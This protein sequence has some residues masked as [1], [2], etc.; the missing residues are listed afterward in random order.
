MPG[1]PLIQMHA[2]SVAG[3]NR[4]APVWFH[5]QSTDPSSDRW[6]RARIADTDVF[7]PSA[8]PT[9]EAQPVPDLTPACVISQS[10][11]TSLHARR[12]E[13]WLNDQLIGFLSDQQDGIQCVQFDNGWSF[14]IDAV[15]EQ[16][17]ML[18]MPADVERRNELMFGPG[19]LL[20]LAARGIFG[21]HASAIRGRDGGVLLLGKSGSGK[22]TLARQAALL[23]HGRLADDV[24][25]LQLRADMPTIL[26]RFPQLKLTP[27]LITA[28]VALPLR[29]L[30]WIEPCEGAAP[31]LQSLSAVT[32][33]RYLLRD[34]VASRLFTPQTLHQ[35][36]GFC[37]QLA[38]R[39]DS[40]ILQLPRVAA[41]HV[42]ALAA[43]A[44]ELLVRE[45]LL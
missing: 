26:P 40:R 18:T 30:L 4:C 20:A 22:S 13:G 8:M 21:L 45:G 16:I 17:S 7:F 37:A 32:A 38:A 29:A 14:C 15:G 28:D 35:H 3:G 43:S 2:G 6:H 34:T 31:A 5:W 33:N 27:S 23:G 41:D 19:L 39:S 42:N 11:N 36:L 9:L 10:R 1:L 25:P 24:V 44:L 12:G